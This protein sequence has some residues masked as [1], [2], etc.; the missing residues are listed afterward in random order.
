MK[1]GWCQKKF[2]YQIALVH[3]LQ[4]MDDRQISQMGLVALKKKLIRYKKIK[5]KGKIEMIVTLFCETHVMIF[6]K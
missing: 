4:R 3:A 5:W 6:E 1:M 2:N